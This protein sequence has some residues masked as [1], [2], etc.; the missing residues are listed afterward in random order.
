V[1]ANPTNFVQSFER[2]LSVIR[3]FDAENPKLTLSE[4]A[5]R[6]DLTRA[7]ARRF[8]M[9]LEQL[10][11]VRSDRRQFELTPR[12]LDIGYAFL[13]ALGLPEVAMPHLEHLAAE[14]QLSSS[15][16]VL[17]GQDIVYVARVMTKRIMSVNINVG[18]RLPAV[19]TSMGRVLL[20]G[21]TDAE[22]DAFLDR[23]AVVAHTDA[24]IV[25]HAALRKAVLRVREL[26]YAFVDQELELGLRAL[27]V[28]VRNAGGKV[29]AA[30][31]LSAPSGAFTADD[32]LDRFLDPLQ[33]AARQIEADFRA[34]DRS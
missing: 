27:A 1:E 13:S 12:V 16:S 31:N 6:A 7:T 11:Y 3:A 33:H 17:D 28:P 8:L 9:T 10:G 4:V 15:V 18:T 29:V 26:G 23:A 34:V 32:V 5:A 2:G 19:T 21:L 22:L 24:T 30:M 20:A 25:D 14:V